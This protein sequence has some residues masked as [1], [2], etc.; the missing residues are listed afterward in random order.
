MDTADLPTVAAVEPGNVDPQQAPPPELTLRAVVAGGIIGALVAA[1]NMYM[2]LKIAFTE[3]GAILSAILCFALIRG[4]GGR[5]SMLEN[6]IGQTLASGAASLGIMVSVIPALIMLGQPLGTFDTMLWLFLVSALG[7]LF[8]IPLRKQFVVIDALPFPT[9][10]ACAATIRAMHARG[11]EAL[12]QA[13]T[14]GIA[15]IISLLFTWFRDGAP[16]FV[17]EMT[18]APFQLGGIP[19]A[20]LAV[21]ISWS[22]MLIGAGLLVGLRIG[23]SLLCGG[24]LGWMA[25]GPVLFSSGVI[26]NPGMRTVSHWTM[27]L[28]IPLMVSA[29]FVTLLIRWRTIVGTFRSMKGARTGTS[30][31]E[32]PFRLWAWG[33]L[34]VG[35]ATALVMEWMLGIP[36]WMGMVAILLSFLLAAVA[37]RAYGKTDVSPIGTMGHATQILFGALAPGQMLPNV[38]TAGITAGCA[39]TAV[40]MMQDLKAGYLLGSTPWRQVVAQFIGVAIGTLIAVPVFSVLVAAY[41]L[42]TEALPAPAA[43][44]WS[45]M[46][47][48]LSVGFSALPPYGWIAVAAGAILGI[49]LALPVSGKWKRL[50]P[51]PLG[52]GIGL[53]IPVAYT[54][55]IFLGAVAGAILGKVAPIWSENK[56]LYVASGL[57]AGEALLGVAI[58][59]LRVAG[60]I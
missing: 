40:D 25:L 17:P 35:L 4:L 10:T 39:N 59:V 53:V 32:V 9:G 34:V 46:A 31:G 45:G 38:M 57:I 54:S 26:E 56:M 6:N 33:T 19:M 37:V 47:E 20:R 60:V 28:A 1:V 21:G 7:V 51:S 11:E 58:A 2:G 41:G 48:L 16:K 44:I 50:L 12:R 49:L 27:W 13:R 8:A 43:V 23:V 24:I 42:G 22:P 15:G 55:I 52:I 18:M 29:G 30:G 3:G 14:L 36:F 5:L